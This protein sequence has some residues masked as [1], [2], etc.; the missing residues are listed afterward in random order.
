M[1]KAN[2][3]VGFMSSSGVSWLGEWFKALNWRCE[4]PG[5]KFRHSSNILWQDINLHLLLSTQVLNGYPVGG[6]SHYWSN[7]F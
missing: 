3:K 7:N 2:H 1:F 4:G 5:F 6:D